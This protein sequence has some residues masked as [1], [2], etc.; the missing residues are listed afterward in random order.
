ML[1]V[2]VGT[3]TTFI[4]STLS[5]RSVLDE[6]VLSVELREW[7]SEWTSKCPSLPTAGELSRDSFST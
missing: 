7:R 1:E 3:T 6:Q 2:E 4:F 5:R